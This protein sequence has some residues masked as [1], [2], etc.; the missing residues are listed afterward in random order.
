MGLKDLIVSSFVKRS[1]TFHRKIPNNII[2]CID[3]QAY[4]VSINLVSFIGQ[5][6]NV[7]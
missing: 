7:S 3:I 4:N 2:L 6:A 5:I 1:P